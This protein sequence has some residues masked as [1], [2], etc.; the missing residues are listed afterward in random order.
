MTHATDTFI[1]RIFFGHHK[2]ATSWIIKILSD[3]AHLNG[4]QLETINS[5]AELDDALIGRLTSGRT[6]FLAFRN[7]DPGSLP[8]LGNFIGFHV[9]RDPRDILVSSYFSHLNSHPTKNW[10][11][12]A[13]HQA[14]LR[15]LTMDAGLLSDMDFCA[16]LMTNGYPVRPFACMAAWDYNRPDIIELKYERLVTDPYSSFLDIFRFLGMLRADEL[17]MNTLSSHLFRIIRSRVFPGRRQLREAIPSWNL[18]STVYDNRFSKKAGGRQHGQE[19]QASHYRKGVPGDWISHFTES[20]KSRFDNLF[21]NLPKRL[22]YDEGQ[23]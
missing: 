12:L 8:R 14:N 7:A 4:F 19:D 17:G 22:G 13:E 20:H 11:E 9:I 10:P 16:E 18:L 15:Q 6:Q 5:A 23:V 3:L 2:A 1:P 21:G